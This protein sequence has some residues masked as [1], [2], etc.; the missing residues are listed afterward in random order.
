M[1][2]RDR[3][4]PWRV[5]DERTV[6]V[7]RPWMELRVQKVSLPSGKEIEDFHRL[8]LPDFVAILAECEGGRFL[9]NRQ[10]KHGIGRYTYTL[11]GGLVEPGETPLA[12]ARREL[13]EETGFHAADWTSLGSAGVH[14]NLGAGTGHYFHA[15]NLTPV[16]RV[17]PDELEEIAV[18]RRTGE[19]I[20]GFVRSGAICLNNHVAAVGLGKIHGLL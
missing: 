8:I 7:S 3:E 9:L 18:L 19:E 12:A 11:Q 16:E 14:G 5:L 1:T 2:E 4:V 10:Y 15:K 13:A 20:C 6:Y 17:E